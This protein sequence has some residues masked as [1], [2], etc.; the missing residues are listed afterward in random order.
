MSLKNIFLNLVAFVIAYILTPLA[1]LF[2]T[3]NTSADKLGFI[4]MLILLFLSF[5]LNLVFT[6][7]QGKQIQIPLL[8]SMI[9]VMLFFIFNTSVIVMIIMMI[10]ASFVGHLL[11]RLFTKKEI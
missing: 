2:F 11:G 5:S 8:S 1:I 4:I 6:Y 10:I 3:K 9:T 7:F